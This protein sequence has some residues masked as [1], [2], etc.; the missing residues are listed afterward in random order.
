[1]WLD[2]VRKCFLQRLMPEPRIVA[3]LA[4]I[5][6]K[7]GK[8]H[9]QS[10]RS[11]RQHSGCCSPHA[12][13]HHGG[14]THEMGGGRGL[15]QCS[16][17]AHTMGGSVGWRGAQASSCQYLGQLKAFVWLSMRVSFVLDDYLNR[18]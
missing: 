16:D 10:H 9:A 2:G 17:K 4:A 18:M 3:S 5:Q 1:M 11:V 14:I 6:G 13:L 8:G 12:V 7:C 15:A